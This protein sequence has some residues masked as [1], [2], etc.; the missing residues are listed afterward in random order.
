MP[1]TRLLLLAALALLLGAGS[2]RGADPAPTASV[3]NGTITVD[4][5]P[6]F[7]IAAWE[8]CSSDVAQDLA[9]GINTFVGSLCDEQAL[10]DAIAGQAYLIGFISDTPNLPAEI[11]YFQTDEPDV[12]G[13]APSALPAPPEDGKITLL[14]VTMDFWSGAAANGFPYAAAFQ[15]ADLLSAD[16]YPLELNCNEQPWVT[17]ETPYDVQLQLSALGKPSGQWLEA[18]AGVVGRCP[19]ALTPAVVQAE[20][21]E[22][23]E[24]GGSWIGW[25]LPPMLG[26][27]PTDSY[28]VAPDIATAIGTVDDQ[29]RGMSA[30]LLSPR[31]AV[32]SPWGDG[33]AT[34]PGSSPVKIGGRVFGGRDYLFATNTTD[35]TVRW[36]GRLP[37]LAARGS[38][39]LQSGGTLE[40][41]RNGVLSELFQPYGTEVVSWTPWSRQGRSALARVPGS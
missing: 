26:S 21:W 36:Q 18:N 29:M 25:Y 33:L 7:M 15:K 35:A 24:G 32:S 31:L 2:A 40:A 30:I 20:A 27:G 41:N 37:G 10:A 4:G 11:G 16:V 39:T 14:N 9:L 19:Y 12:H 13:I 6:F 23:I 5:Q 22:V 3:V 34:G 8:Q 38:V 1:R 28:Q 17:L